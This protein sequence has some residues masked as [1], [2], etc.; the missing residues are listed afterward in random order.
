MIVS[1]SGD[2]LTEGVPGASY[3]D[4]LKK[5]LPESELIN[6]GEGGDTVLSLYKRITHLNLEKPIDIA[7]LWI[8]TNTYS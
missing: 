4:V 3:F 8:G 1:F 2:S 7:F 5:R 6:L